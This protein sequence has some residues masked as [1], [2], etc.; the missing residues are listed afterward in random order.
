MERKQLRHDHD[1]IPSGG[2]IGEKQGGPPPLLVLTASGEKPV[3]DG[4]VV[5]PWTF[6]A[7]LL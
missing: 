5:H 6:G 7:G 3:M 1:G 4:S 2:R